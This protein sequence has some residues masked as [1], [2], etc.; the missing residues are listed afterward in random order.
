MLISWTYR[1]DIY[2]K[3]LARGTQF[4]D[5][6]EEHDKFNRNFEILID[7]SWILLKELNVFDS[8]FDLNKIDKLP[9]YNKYIIM[10]SVLTNLFYYGGPESEFKLD[11]DS[12]QEPVFSSSSIVST[13]VVFY[14]GTSL[15]TIN[16]I[17]DHKLILPQSSSDSLAVAHSFVSEALAIYNF[18]P[19]EDL[20]S[21]LWIPVP[22]RD[23]SRFPY[24]EEVL[25]VPKLKFLQD[26][27]NNENKIT[28]EFINSGYKIKSEHYKEF[29]HSQAIAEVSSS[30]DKIEAEIQ[31]VHMS[32]LSDMEERQKILI[33]KK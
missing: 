3:T 14:F 24:E 12:Q 9:H 16:Q 25:L 5:K 30:E 19:L 22:I 28:P 33:E 6:T 20:D 27:I 8:I 32:Q 2:I 17:R 18:T 11:F 21:E 4:T 7:S 31:I 26:I 10:L 15:E 13:N 23:Y 29:M 1:G